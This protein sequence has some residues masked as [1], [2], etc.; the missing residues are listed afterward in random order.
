[1]EEFAKHHASQLYESAT[2]ANEDI[3]SHLMRAEDQLEDA[4][5]EA[6]NQ[7]RTALEIRED[8]HDQHVSQLQTQHSEQFSRI[9]LGSCSF[10]NT[11]AG[12]CA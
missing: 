10:E 6:D 7:K 1:M 5:H 4:L 11:A 2:M 3:I 12:K 8:E 9:I